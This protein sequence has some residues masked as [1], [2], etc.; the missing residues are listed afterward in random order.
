MFETTK[1]IEMFC[2]SVRNGV[3]QWYTLSNRITI[4]NLGPDTSPSKRPHVRTAPRHTVRGEVQNRTCQ[5]NHI[6]AVTELKSSCSLH[7][8]TY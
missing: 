2:F 5:L 3:M 8:L 6:K 7:I 1:Q 4:L